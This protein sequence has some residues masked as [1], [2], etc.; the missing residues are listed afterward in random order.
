MTIWFS[1]AEHFRV[2]LYSVV[3][4]I[5]LGIIYDFVK[6]SRILLGISEYSETAKKLSAISLPLIKKKRTAQKP[7][8][9]SKYGIVLIFIGDIIYSLICAGVYSLFLFHAI[10]GLVRWYFIIASAA[11]F[12]LYY[13]TLSKFIIVIIE[14]LFF[15]VKTLFLYAAFIILLPFRLLYRFLK[16][17][18]RK[19]Y[20]R[21]ISPLKSRMV[22]S[23]YKK[24]TDKRLAQ[25]TSEL[26]ITEY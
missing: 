2:M 25:I 14:I 17:L 7:K 4:G 15:S 16:F 24:Y 9:S 19:L 20:S 12:F 22:Y 10:R 21:I 8:G 5:L 3:I 26:Q 1:T 18:L 11:G 13:F 23:M 6:M